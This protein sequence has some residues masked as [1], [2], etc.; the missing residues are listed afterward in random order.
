MTKTGWWGVDFNI[1]LSTNLMNPLQNLTSIQLR[2][3]LF[4][5]TSA[6]AASSLVMRNCLQK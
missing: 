2:T 4:C 1:M 3:A 5:Q 6:R